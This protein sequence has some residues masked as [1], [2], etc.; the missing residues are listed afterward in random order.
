MP[1]S[2]SQDSGQNSLQLS[3]TF[4]Q[5]RGRKDLYGVDGDAIEEYDRRL[6]NIFIL[7]VRAF[8]EQ[9]LAD[10]TKLISTLS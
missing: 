7:V 5:E 10:R 1:S 3:Q 6:I 4:C 2:S 8:E 9:K